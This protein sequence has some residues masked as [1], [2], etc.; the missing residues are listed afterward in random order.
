[1]Q[2]SDFNLN[3]KYEPIKKLYML[4][5]EYINEDGH[6]AVLKSGKLLPVARNRVSAFVKTLKAL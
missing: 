3:P 2:L 5:K 6:F 1:M 4:F